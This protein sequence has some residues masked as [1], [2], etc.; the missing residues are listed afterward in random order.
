MELPRRREN[1]RTFVVSVWVN[2]ML[3]LSETERK[4]VKLLS[5][6]HD[7]LQPFTFYMRA[8][9]PPAKLASALQN[10]ERNDIVSIDS[11]VISLTDTGRNW[12]MVNRKKLSSSEEAQWKDVP[13]EFRNAPSEPL[14]PYLPRRSYLDPSLIP[15]QWRKT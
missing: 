7:A 8:R 5:F 13:L 3:I 2:N 15:K 6:S 11:S 14:S 4:I 1:S 12:V 10:L 9:I